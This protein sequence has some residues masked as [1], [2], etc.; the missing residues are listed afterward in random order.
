MNDSLDDLPEVCF[1]TEYRG[2][3]IEVSLHVPL[4]QITFAVSNNGQ[5]PELKLFFFYRKHLN[6]LV[7]NILKKADK[8]ELENLNGMLKYTSPHCLFTLLGLPNGNLYDVSP[9]AAAA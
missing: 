3:I 4:E 7:R 2:Q 9:R 8:L 1:R 6:T 5:T